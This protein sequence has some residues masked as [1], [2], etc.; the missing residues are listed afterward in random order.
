MFWRQRRYI[1]ALMLFLGFFNVYSL[2]VNVSIAIVPM[3][4]GVKSKSH[5]LTK[6]FDWNSKEQGLAL[7]SFFYGYICTQFIG[8][9]CANKIGGRRSQ[10]QWNFVF[11]IAAAIYLI[12]CVI[13]WF[14]ASGELQPWAKPTKNNEIQLKGVQIK[15][16]YS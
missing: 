2:R 7:S 4:Y 8:G 16:S 3:I 15:E 10:Q 14:F 12:G 13:Y 9:V 11:I 6:H 5:G 1:V